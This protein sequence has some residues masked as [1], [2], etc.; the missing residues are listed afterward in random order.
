MNEISDTKIAAYCAGNRSSLTPAEETQ[1]RNIEFESRLE[2]VNPDEDND[3]PSTLLHP[4][5]LLE[6]IIDYAN[7]TAVCFQPL[8][9]LGAALTI[10]GTIFGRRYQDESGQRS[11]LYILGVGFTSAGKDHALKVVQRVFDAAEATKLMLGQITSDSALEHV[12]TRQ[13]RLAILLDEAGYFLSAV[14]EANSGSSLKTIRPS[15][16]QLWSCANSLWVGKQRAPQRDKPEV[17]VE[18]KCPH[19]SLFGMTQPQVFYSGVRKRDLQDGWLAR[20]IF[21][22]SKTRPMGSIC[23]NCLKPVPESIVNAVRLFAEEADEV[24]TVPTSREAVMVLQDF[25]EKTHLKMREADKGKSEISYLY[26]KAVELARRVALIHAISRNNIDLMIEEEDMRWAVTLIDWSISKSIDAITTNVAENATEAAKLLI[27]SKITAAGKAGLSRSALT[28]QT[29]SIDRPMRN[30]CL[31]D[32]IES[33]EIIT[34]TTPTGGQI[35]RLPP[36]RKTP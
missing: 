27:L 14:S 1:M 6:E 3:I 18:I 31:D 10:C 26:G 20:F 24:R 4:G 16:L 12:L 22:I 7:E 2:T 5:G 36:S 35:F 25:H 8:F 19:V 30:N 32:L 28:R 21:L 34:T 17:A 29:Q 23:P 11:N 9:A 33:G 15:L 13:K